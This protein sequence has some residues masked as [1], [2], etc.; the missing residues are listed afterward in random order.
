MVYTLPRA[1]KE[2][3]KNEERVGSLESKE[4]AKVRQL[5]E[6]WQNWVR[7]VGWHFFERFSGSSKERERFLFSVLFWFLRGKKPREKGF[8]LVPFFS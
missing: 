3:K 5:K 8:V 6:G 4:R 1:I 7:G 2:E